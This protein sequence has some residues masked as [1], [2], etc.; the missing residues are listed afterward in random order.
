MTTAILLISLGTLLRF[1][2]LA[3]LGWNAVPLMAIALYAGARLPRRWAIAVPLATM[4]T[5]DIVLDWGTTRGLLDYDRLAVYA[6]LVGRPDADEQAAK[7][8][9]AHSAVASTVF[10]CEKRFAARCDSESR[11]KING[12]PIISARSVLR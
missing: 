6:C 7:D 2:H 11:L 9:F 3:G 12:I 4:I 10:F 5:S 8:H 1:G